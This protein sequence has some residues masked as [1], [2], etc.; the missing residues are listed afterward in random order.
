MKNILKE[1]DIDEEDEV[2]KFDD[3][4]D[5]EY[6]PEASEQEKSRIL[7]RIAKEKE[8]RD[9]NRRKR[10]TGASRFRAVVY[11]VLLHLVLRKING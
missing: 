2:V 7:D 11:V 1:L 3:N 8:Q 9:R 5:F 6:D 10:C 4:L